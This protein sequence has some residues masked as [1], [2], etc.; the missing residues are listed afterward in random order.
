MLVAGVL[1]LIMDAARIGIVGLP[2][3]WWF[4]RLDSGTVVTAI[5][6]AVS[7]CYAIIGRLASGGSP[8]ATILLAS[9]SR[10]AS[11]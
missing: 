2:G 6:V 7:T 10:R 9:L 11:E 1:I 3:L 5:T 8:D 4:R